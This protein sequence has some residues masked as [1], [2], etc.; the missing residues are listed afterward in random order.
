M[1]L[2]LVRKKIII[3]YNYSI[4]D[5]ALKR[6]STI[7]VTL[8]TMSLDNQWNHLTKWPNTFKELLVLL[9]DARKSDH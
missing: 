8:E 6:V 2:D 1:R 4:D 5:V 3:P 7:V 9:K